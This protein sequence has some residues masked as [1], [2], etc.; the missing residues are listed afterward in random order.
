M[1][2]YWDISRNQQ[3]NKW[4]DKRRNEEMTEWRKGWTK[5][6]KKTIKWIRE[7]RTNDLARKGWTK[8][9]CDLNLCTEFHLLGY[10]QVTYCW[11]KNQT[12]QTK[13]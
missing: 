13:T 9:L 2:F 1:H 11:E 4:T 10:V 3:M 7:Q 8:D 12:I 6:L 5:E